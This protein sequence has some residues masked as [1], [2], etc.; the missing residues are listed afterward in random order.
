MPLSFLGL[1]RTVFIFPKHHSHPQGFAEAT[2]QGSGPSPDQVGK[3]GWRKLS[4]LS[5]VNHCGGH[6]PPASSP[7]SSSPG[8]HGRED[9]WR[10]GQREN[11]MFE[12]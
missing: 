7:C 2:P 12:L 10:T 11:L 4:D 3:A 5:K 9:G 8:L 6:S 1:G